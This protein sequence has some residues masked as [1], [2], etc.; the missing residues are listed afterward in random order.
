MAKQHNFKTTKSTEWMDDLLSTMSQGEK[1]LF[2]RTAITEYAVAIGLVSLETT[3]PRF[4]SLMGPTNTP[5]ETQ[6]E[7]SGSIKVLPKEN[8]RKTK[9]TQEEDEREA[10]ETQKEDVSTS[11]VVPEDFGEPPTLT[12]TDVV[13][14]TEPD[15]DSALDNINF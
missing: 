7:D 4:K 13:E 2:I 14:D 12:A 5:E 1:S 6:Q 3:K 9:V 10:K 15:L 11:Q 8:E